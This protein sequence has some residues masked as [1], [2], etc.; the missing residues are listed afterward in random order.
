MGLALGD[1][2]RVHNLCERSTF[3]TNLTA[4]EGNLTNLTN[5]R[6]TNFTDANKWDG[7]Y[8]DGLQAAQPGG[9]DVRQRAKCSSLARLPLHCSFTGYVARRA[10]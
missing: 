5:S 3:V 6:V 4:A 9:Y 7:P 8:A 10:A 1:Q 2:V